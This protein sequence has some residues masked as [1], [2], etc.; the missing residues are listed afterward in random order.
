MFYDIEYCV[1]KTPRRLIRVIPDPVRKFIRP[2][3][4]PVLRKLLDKSSSTLS[5]WTKIH[6]IENGTFKNN[7]Y[8]RIM[9]AMAEEPDDGFLRG[10]VVADFGCGPRGSLVWA[11]SAS[12]RIGVDVLADR[13]AD[14]FPENTLS[15]GMVYLKSTEKVI[16]LPTEF[17][18]TVFTLNAMDHVDSFAD[19]CR[20][21]VRILK[22]GGSFIGSFNIGGRAT[23]TEPQS[24]N[25]KIIQENIMKNLDVKSYRLAKRGSVDN[26][27]GP[28]LEGNESY[29]E[30]QEGF[31]WVRGIKHPSFS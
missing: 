3:T 19:M 12:L 31:L 10:K 30:G 6:E 22:T 28:L 7:H 20:E 13:Y 18:D 14:M 23:E 8:R 24:L 21:V 16:P 2:F 4:L 26:L 25:E 11:S 15:H 29:E 17:V 1:M 27:Y 5:Y 9:L